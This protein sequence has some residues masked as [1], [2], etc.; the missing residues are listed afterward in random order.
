M[1]Q[2]KLSDG[3]A[4]RG[5]GRLIF[6]VRPNGLKT[7]FYQYFRN[8]KREYIRIGKFKDGPT[9]TG[10]TLAEINKKFQELANFHILHGDVKDHINQLEKQEIQER[11]AT[12]SIHTTLQN[13]LD[14]YLREKDL[15]EGTV[16]DY[17]KA[18]NEVFSDYLDRPITTINREAILNLY[19]KRVK[20]S[21]ARANNSMRVFRAIYNY[22]RAVTRLDDG[23]YLLPES[24]VGVLSDTNIIRKLKRRNTYIAEDQMKIWF[25]SVYSLDN[26]VYD[27]GHVVRDFLLFALLT[28]TRLQEVRT[29]ASEDV[30]VERGIF[31]L[32]DT[33]NKE[34]VELPMSDFVNEIAKRRKNDGG[35][36]LFNGNKKNSPL[37]SLKRPL[38]HIREAVKF[39]FTVHD[40]RRTFIT[41]GESL[42][43]SIYT[44]KRL[45]NHKIQESNDVTAGYVVR[46]VG[47]MKIATQRITDHILSLAGLGNTSLNVVSISKRA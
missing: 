2:Y 33:K 14:S 22:H 9:D 7:A 10:Y 17:K 35:K 43:I 28:G 37:V 29:L 21:P 6:D 15:K 16:K 41:V 11:K 18:M 3:S 38:T 47:R 24:P 39:H 40:L 46:D 4:L 34:T 1:T 45:V 23:T 20:E 5:E 32:R 12:D 36:Y 44:V 26:S 19:K 27:S 25:D 13:V 8:G 30:N 42:D 31:T